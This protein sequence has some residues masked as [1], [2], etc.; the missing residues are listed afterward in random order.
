MPKKKYHFKTKD[1]M[2]REIENGAIKYLQMDY[3]NKN[4]NKIRNN[5][6]FKS[7]GVD[8][9]E[10]KKKI[11][12]KSMNQKEKKNLNKNK[13]YEKNRYINDAKNKNINESTNRNKNMKNKKPKLNSSTTINSS[14]N[15]INAKRN[16]NNDYNETL[17]NDYLYPNKKNKEFNIFQ[18]EYKNILKFNKKLRNDSQENNKENKNNK[19][20]RYP[21]GLTMEN[22]KSIDN[23][24]SDEMLNDFHCK[25]CKLHKGNSM[26]KKYLCNFKDCPHEDKKSIVKYNPKKYNVAPSTTNYTNTETP[27]TTFPGKYKNN[28]SKRKG[29]SRE[30]TRMNNK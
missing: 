30:L 16:K 7:S 5:R 15:D 28:N 11:Y 1:E 20:K 2:E 26:P 14:T 10:L 25:D 12:N 23:D 24:D 3:K 8:E 6:V 19:S 13:S 9:G 17:S 22:N 29:Y 4:K 27:K 21:F 18:K